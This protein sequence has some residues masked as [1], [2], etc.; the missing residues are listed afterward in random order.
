MLSRKIYREIARKNGV[1][2]EKVKKEMQSAINDSYVNP[3]FYAR[4]VPRREEVPTVDEFIE[5]MANRVFVLG[6]K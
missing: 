4:C 1:S 3:S 5:Y 2:I 6:N